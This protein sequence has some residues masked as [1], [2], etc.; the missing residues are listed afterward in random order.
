MRFTFIGKYDGKWYEL[1][2]NGIRDIT[3]EFIS[4]HYETDYE[5]IGAA[6]KILKW[7][8]V[9]DGSL[10]NHYFE[11]VEIHVD[12]RRIAEVC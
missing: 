4:Y 10:F 6:R 8:L 2:G 7:V 3:G 11:S 12:N 1:Q 5:A 9:P